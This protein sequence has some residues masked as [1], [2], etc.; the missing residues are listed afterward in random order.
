MSRTLLVVGLAC[1]CS[2]L[3][4][5]YSRQGLTKYKSIETPKQSAAKE[6]NPVL[7]QQELEASD[8]SKEAAIEKKEVKEVKEMAEVAQEQD[9]TIQNE[10][11][12]ES[13][14]ILEKKE[15][16]LR[17]PIVQ[18]VGTLRD[19][20]GRQVLRV[21]P[22]EECIHEYLNAWKPRP[23]DVIICTAPKTGTTWLQMVNQYNLCS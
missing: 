21:K 5:Y 1:A 10:V 14:D 15:A 12:K 6:I 20:V 4:L 16:R 19:L 11:E 17:K 9:N 7:P 8:D 23:S 2:G 18:N 22:G 13:T 3:I